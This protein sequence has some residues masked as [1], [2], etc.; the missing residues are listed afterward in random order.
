MTFPQNLPASWKS[1]LIRMQAAM[2]L[3]LSVA[4]CGYMVGAPYQAHIQSVHVPIFSSESFRRGIEFELTEAVHKEIQNRTHFR[5]TK[6]PYA[7][8]RLTGK[9]VHL[10]KRVLGESAYGPLV[11]RK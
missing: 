10:E 1:P 3:L 2:L 9:I 4:G 5:L 7:D 6:A 8:S 11:S